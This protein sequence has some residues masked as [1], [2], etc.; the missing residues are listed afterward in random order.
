MKNF[1]FLFLIL[2]CSISF[3][4]NERFW[5]STTVNNIPEQNRIS[6]SGSIKNPIYLS[7]NI[8]ALKSTLSAA[9]G[10]FSENVS[11]VKIDIPNPEGGFDI[12]EIYSTPTMAKSMADNLPEIKSYVG[13]NVSDRKHS[14]RITI[15]PQGFYAMTTGSETGQTFINPY[16]K[17]SNVYILFSKQHLEKDVLDNFSCEVLEEAEYEIK[18]A[19][20]LP[21]F[22]DDGILRQYRF[23]V[24]S[25]VEYSNFHWQ[26]AGVS[27]GAPDT[28][29]KAAVQAAMV[30]TMDRVNEIYERDLGVTMQFIS[31]NQDVI[32]LGNTSSDPYTNNDGFAMLSENQTV[33]NN[34]IGAANYD[35]GHVFSTGG[36]G[37]A[38]LNSVCSSGKARGV[39]GLPNP[40]GEPFDIDY[41]A[42]EIGHQFGANHTQNNNCQRNNPTAM[43]PGSANTI[44]GY[45][46]ICSPNVQN[47]SDAMFHYISISEI[48]NSFVNNGTGGCAQNINISNTAPVI[49][50]LPNYVIPRNTPFRLEADAT[51]VNGDNLTYS[52]EQIDN[53]IATMPPIASSTGGPSFR[54]FLPTTDPIRYFPGL[55]TLLAN[56]YSNTWEVLPNVNRDLN[57]AVV[58]RDNN[59]LG[60][61]VSTQSTTLT[62]DASTGPFRVTSQN[63]S[64]IV[65]LTGSSE[66]ITWDVAN[67]NSGTVN[68]LEVDIYLS[69]DGGL[70]YSTAVLQN[71]P[72]DGTENIIVPNIETSNARL[73]V[74][75]SDN[76]F[77]DI[78][79]EAFSIE[80]PLYCSAGPTISQDSEIEN[81]T[82]T[83]ENNSI[84]NNT[85]NICTGSAGGEISDFTNQSADLFNGSSYTLSVEF[86]DCDGAPQFDGAGG[87]WIDW[88]NDGD[89]SDLNEEIGKVDVGVSSGNVTQ[90]FTINLPS[91]QSP[92]NYR[93]RIVQQQGVT[94]SAVN[95][96]TVFDY[97]AVEDYTI[98]VIEI[99][100]PTVSLSETS[101]SGLNYSLN[102][103]PSTAQ[104]FVIQG[105]D[106]SNDVLITS[107]VNFE[108]SLSP[109]LGFAGSLSLT[110]TSG[111][112][113]PTTIYVRLVSGLSEGTY[114]GSLTADSLGAPQQVIN[115]SGAVLPFSYCDAGP[116][117]SVDS[118]IENVTLIGVN[119]SI[120]NNTTDVCT[121]A[122]GGEISDFTNLSADLFNGGSYT[123]TVE[124]GDCNGGSQFNGAGGIWI[125]WNNDGDFED[126]NEDIGTADVAVSAGNVIE[127]FTINVPPTQSPGNYRMRIV[128]EEGTTSADVNPC[129][130]FIWGAVED[131]TIEVIPTPSCTIFEDFEA[132][133]PVGWFTV[134]NTGPCDWANQSATP[135]GDDFPT[136]AMVFDD[137]ACGNGAP[138]SNV[139][140]LSDVYDTSGASSILIGYD[141]AF[142]QF[143][144]GQ[145][146]TVEVFDGVAWQ[147]IALYDTDLV[148]NIQTEAGIDATAY[149]NA[150]FQVRWTYD[151]GGIW[152]WYAGID[153][154]CLTLSYN[155]WEGTV[156]TDWNTPGNWSLGTVPT[157]ADS[158]VIT[159]VPNQ[160][161]IDASITAEVDNLI[162]NSNT[163]VSVEGVFNVSGD[164]T[165]DG[166]IVFRSSELS[167]SGQFDTFTGTISGTGE[168]TV[169]RYIPAKR[170]FRLLA[171][172]VTTTDFIF[173]NWQE[174]GSTPATS[175][176]LGTHITGG[177]ASLGFDQ[178]DSG[179]PS[180]F[181]FDSA[182]QSWE[183]LQNTNATKLIAGEAYLT[184]VRGDRTID[185]ADNDYPANPTILRSTGALLTGATSPTL[186]QQPGNYNLVANPYQAVVDYSSVMKS[187]LTDFIYVWDAGITG[188]NGRGG[189]VTLDISG[190]TTP[191]NPFSSDASEFI[192]PGLSFFV[193]NLSSGTISPSLTFDE[194]NKA[195]GENQVTVFNTYPYFYINSRLYISSDLQNG[196]SERDAIGLR[197]SDNYTTLGSDEDGTKLGNPDEN[198][199]VI[200]N[201]L[202]SIDKQALPD[203]GHEIDLSITNYTTNNYSLTFVIENKPEGLGVFLADNY[204]NTQ[205][206]LTESVVYDFA[207]DQNIPESMS[208]N[209]FS[210]VFDN[211]TLGVNENTFGENFSLYPNPTTDGLFS[212]QTPNVSGE[213]QVEIFNLLGQ[214]VYQQ[215]LSVEDQQVDVDAKDL[216]SGV[217]LVTLLQKEQSYSAKLIVE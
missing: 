125:D 115:L 15:T 37:I 51:D 86:G 46:G 53:E 181:T 90:D 64:G 107:P 39:T 136:L 103:G 25:T 52:W 65:W 24:A 93:M 142:Q 59:A 12:F 133:L 82:L 11:A 145:S 126:P 137:D 79:Q 73:M 149:A 201:G 186:D 170:A 209:R 174:N 48:S 36:G 213:V 172:P 44:M 211:T 182:N 62:V 157:S 109:G 98:E 55:P 19:Q 159:D 92:G 2:F 74:K 169:E 77:F 88:N 173:E 111:E 47:N 95:P 80:E 29:K 176:E 184:M 158:A 204:L 179:A 147:Q 120:T 17:D 60:G 178:N 16:A 188:D 40:V 168:V 106:L 216:S 215:E 30:V 139:S 13:Y 194:T 43:E 166:E 180:M 35:I 112:L 8:D 56:N 210:L 183:A 132:G 196:N 76:V 117:S 190:S 70:T 1:I 71:T 134:V 212:L 152:A 97:G 96:C 32:Y 138:A 122:P 167:G 185:L 160:P 116:T 81:V 193:Q 72:N 6:Y 110:P 9:P 119:N 164:I 202:R 165:N 197:F 18:S 10:R 23:G 66:T 14:L 118:E 199:A 171:S 128:Q 177:D 26:A 205:T 68:A 100:N 75:A 195:T 34:V 141:V 101:I 4:Q 200:N 31:N 140:I 208:E 20:G 207:V 41:V 84:A 78:N 108:I 113:S 153:N 99:P 102:S 21:K 83:G 151:D 162:L 57:F 148:P 7:L 163:T 28:D 203:L 3:A 150:N 155:N 87:V 85:T 38:S 121:G 130:T 33:F 91:N 63:S 192:P 146:F 5:Q 123:L 206:E 27:P 135:T 214:K 58:V 67:T 175:D 187:D 104:S 45:A 198:Y 144:S 127:D 50:T 105:S 22:I 154:F 191:P 69:T 49:Q 61:Q 94:A 131:Y 89:F 114:S 54:T 124:F 42:H 129:G 161:L 189:Y 156:S 143:N 217:Y